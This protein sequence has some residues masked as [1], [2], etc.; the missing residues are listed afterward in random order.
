MSKTF[1]KEI[2]KE[3]MLIK[4]IRECGFS[5]VFEENTEGI[6]G[7]CAIFNTDTTYEIR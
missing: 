7:S 3:S 2:Y 1:A 4:Y 5:L 6:T